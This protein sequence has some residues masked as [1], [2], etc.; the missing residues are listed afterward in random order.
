MNPWDI[1]IWLLVAIVAVIFLAILI[2]V[3]F[4]IVSFTLFLHDRRK[5]NN[6]ANEAVASGM[7]AFE[8]FNAGDDLTIAGRKWRVNEIETSYDIDYDRDKVLLIL[9]SDRDDLRH[10][11]LK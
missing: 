9:S 8:A 10:G 1:L 5:A 6:K 11:D 7:L 2:V 4:A 3:I